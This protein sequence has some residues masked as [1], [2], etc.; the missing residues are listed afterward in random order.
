MKAPVV[1]LTDFGECDGYAG[2]LRLVLQQHFPDL[3]VVDLSHDLEPGAILSA[4]FVLASAVPYAPH[5]S[6]F[7]VVVDPGVGTDRAV[8]VARW[9]S[10][11]VVAP[12]NGLLSL[13]VRLYG[14]PYCYTVEIDEVRELLGM[15]PAVSA[16]FHGRDVFAPLAGLLASGREV[17]LL[18]LGTPVLLPVARPQLPEVTG[19][20]ALQVLHWDR[21]GNGVLS[22]HR[23]ECE[24]HSGLSRARLRGRGIELQ[25]GVNTYGEVAPGEFLLYWGSSGWL[26]LAVR[27][28]S[29]ASRLAFSTEP[30]HLVLP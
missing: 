5:S 24:A 26:E 23:S 27:D 29:A 6:V 14:T 30:F 2:V 7:C 16:T 25:G 19:V 3:P 9:P 8:L 15:R 11:T 4:A 17:S 18:A 1:L 21:F 13:C 22:L 12:D 20:Y 28:G 10:F